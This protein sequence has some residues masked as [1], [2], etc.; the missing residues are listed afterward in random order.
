MSFHSG[1]L[2]R[3]GLRGSRIPQEGLRV[4]G[5][6]QEG[7]R[8]SIVLME[9]MRVSR[10][11]Q[12]GIKILLMKSKSNLLLKNIRNYSAR[13]WIVMKTPRYNCLFC[14]SLECSL[15]KGEFGVF[16][17]LYKCT[18]ILMYVR[19]NCYFLRESKINLLS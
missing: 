17:V 19:I 7:L 15:H 10:V 12:E 8:G 9:C 4:W 6:P 13:I 11:P 1:I 16:E 14:R 18:N 3:G 2:L 5:F